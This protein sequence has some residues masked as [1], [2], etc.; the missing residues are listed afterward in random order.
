M[1][2]L[3]DMSGTW[4]SGPHVNNPYLFPYTY[5]VV[6]PIKASHKL[7]KDNGVKMLL[8]LLSDLDLGN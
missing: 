3:V 7:E 2:G 5:N 8:L 6:Y 1:L 4:D